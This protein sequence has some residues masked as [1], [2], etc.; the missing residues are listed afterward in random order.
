MRI[1]IGLGFILFA[2]IICF[3]TAYIFFKSF[4]KIGEEDE[5]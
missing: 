4:N 3:I 2:I 1:I 5:L